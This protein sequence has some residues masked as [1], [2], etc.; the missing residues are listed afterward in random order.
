M[1]SVKFQEPNGLFIKFKVPNVF[2]NVIFEIPNISLDV[3]N[4][5]LQL[6]CI[7]FEVY[8]SNLMYRM[9]NLNCRFKFKISS[10]KFQEHN[11]EPNIN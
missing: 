8:V 5:I 2:P 9:S 4:I 3:Q 11:F 10:V 7:Q 1:S 6:L